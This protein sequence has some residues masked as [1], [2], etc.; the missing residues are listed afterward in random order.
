MLSLSA[1]TTGPK[2]RSGW[3]SIGTGR[4]IKSIRGDPS[5]H[6]VQPLRHR[7]HLGRRRALARHLGSDESDLRRIDPRTVEVLERLE[8]PPGTSV[9][10]LESDGGDRFFCGGG[11]SGKV[12][13][14]RRPGRVG[15]AGRGTA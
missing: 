2:G 12:R 10:G 15:A 6:R 5:H 13:A 14:V 7:G 9:S 4:S 8:M 11:S 1:A 3:G